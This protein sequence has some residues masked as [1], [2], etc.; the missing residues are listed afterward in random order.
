M[1]SCV[2][3]NK[4]EYTASVFPCAFITYTKMDVKEELREVGDQSVPLF[5]LRTGRVN[6]RQRL[7]YVTRRQS[8]NRLWRL[9]SLRH[10][11]ELRSQWMQDCSSVIRPGIRMWTTHSQSCCC[12]PHIWPA[13][14]F[15]AWMSMCAVQKPVTFS[16]VCAAWVTCWTRG[17]ACGLKGSQATDVN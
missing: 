5:P 7:K 11:S 12:L 16:C 15:R 10:N 8:S 13:V 9:D 4:A 3:D 1:K 2:S 17:S 14:V 6:F